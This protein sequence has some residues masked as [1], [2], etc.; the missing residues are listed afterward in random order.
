MDL[1]ALLY[2]RELVKKKS[3]SA[4]TRLADDS[5]LL[6]MPPMSKGSSNTFFNDCLFMLHLLSG[7]NW[8]IVFEKLNN[9]DSFKRESKTTLFLSYFGL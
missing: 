1:S 6:V 7:I 3:K 8:M 5:L 4:N 9:F 2:L